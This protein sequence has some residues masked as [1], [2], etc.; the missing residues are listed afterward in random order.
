MSVDTF[1]TK[2]ECL[3]VASEV[4]AVS[5]AYTYSYEGNEWPRCVPYVFDGVAK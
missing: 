4:K 3:A 1:D 2:A 5:L